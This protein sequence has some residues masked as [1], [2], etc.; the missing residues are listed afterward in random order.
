M[1]KKTVFI[2]TAKGE[3]EISNLSGDL[4][5]ALSLIDNRST[6]DEVSRRAPPS[7]REDL[8]EVLG[9]LLAGEYI[10]DRDR[11]AAEP[12]IV[13]PKIATPKI[14]QPK[15]FVP[16]AAGSSGELD[17]TSLGSGSSDSVAAK[18]MGKDDEDALAR[19]E[20]EI[21]M[22][23]SGN[24]M[25][26]EDEES[27]QA[28][29][30]AKVAAA[31]KARSSLEA[32]IDA[33]KARASAEAAAKAEAKARQEAE[34]AARAKAAA[35]A[36]ALQEATIRAQ[37]EAKAK[38][39]AAARARAEQE[40]ARAKSALEAA[41]RAK[42]EAEAK[43][44][45]EIEAAARAKQIAEAKA[46]QEAAEAKARQEA[47]A[48]RLKAE[49]EAARVRAE[50]EAAAKAKAAAEAARVQ[51]ELEAARVKAEL[52]A[53][54]ARAEA[55]AKALA[56]AIAKREAEEKA[57]R[58]AE[59]ARL[60]AEQEA[61]A[62]RLRAEQEAE[63]ARL[64]AEQEA[65]AK[66]KLEAETKARLE[67][68]ARVKVEQEAAAKA[69]QEAEARAKA[70]SE[71]RAKAESEA[72][73]KAEAEAKAQAEEQ[74]RKQAAV[75]GKNK[76]SGTGSFKL[77]LD[78]FSASVPAA[79][80]PRMLDDER[81]HQAREKAE[82]MAKREAEQRAAEQPAG[83]ASGEKAKKDMA[84]EMARLKAEADA[85][86][87]KAEE[88]ARRQAEERALAEEQAKAWAEAEQ[89]ALAQAKIDAEMAAQ[90]AALAQAK[91]TTKSAP[92]PKR[93]P[94]P[95]GKI[96]AGLVV[97]ALIIAIALPY[98]YPL[99]EYIPQIEQRLAAQMKQPV[100][101]GVM[102]AASIPP[103]L[104]LQNVTVGIEQEVK[105][106]SVE[107]NFDLLSL[108]SETRAIGDAVLDDVSIKGSQLERFSPSMLLAGGDR[109]FPVRHFTLRKVKVVTEEVALPNLSG[110]AEL[111]P[112][113]AFSRVALHSDDEKY[114]FDLQPVQGRWQLAV[115]LKETALP[116]LPGVV[117]SD[118]NAK[119]NLGDGEVDFN[120]IDGH[121][122]KGILLGSAK[123]N[124]R[125]GWQLQG[126]LEAKL[127][128]L[129]KMF[130]AN[131]VEGQMYGE[132]TFAFSG[133]R[134]SQLGE[135][136]RLD[137]SF[138]VK[139]G[140]VNAIDM[141]ETARLLSREHM[142]GGR[143][144][145]DD[146]IGVVQV[147]NHNVRFRQLKILSNML[148][149]N[150]SFDV[151]TGGQLSGSFNAEIKMRAGSNP[152]TLYGTLAEP[153]LRAG[154]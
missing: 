8:Y 43:V 7:L 50:L 44:R 92:R 33:A 108:F 26:I 10:R 145:F 24:R 62:A 114:S 4:R 142:V 105:I 6:V 3:N 98:V 11:A 126:R 60:K 117:F 131:G 30:K 19:A 83:A 132:G 55:E 40:A 70:E 148:S 27:K 150:G 99:Q 144:R 138:T 39:E 122:F 136:P 38:M 59:A 28:R 31:E 103:K 146:M 32:G 152:L 45:A 13:A 125:K 54:K 35:E 15:M 77:D 66:A 1:D 95:W 110:V 151:G 73:R 56:E 113:G 16:K 154:R 86:R 57:R 71:A 51:A 121:I 63:A 61:E 81:E 18:P 42:A 107:L 112:Q 85:A 68:E 120:E 124:W 25:P 97:L 41:S 80:P 147:E 37:A 29:L 140:N 64:K 21:A 101:I 123:L 94:L 74:A 89:R 87:L 127:F 17:F 78:Q 9:E 49:E 153:K 134:F 76:G 149:A 115:S 36:K 46:K 130:P 104:K 133:A 2:K 119:G 106:A 23:Q 14:T 96:S 34:M 90:Q 84:T 109:Q 143:T 67:A 65:A 82:A 5:R 118:L 116:W 58:E 100:K 135:S 111:D 93:A 47:E 129:D 137:A 75:S 20:L 128:E 139:G 102:T 12:R 22:A 72:R 69:K 48:A 53:A 52:E 141:V 88:E 79:E 91:E